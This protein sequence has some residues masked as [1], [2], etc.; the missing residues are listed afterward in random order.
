MKKTLILIIS[1]A[2][3]FSA[4]GTPQAYEAI[5]FITPEKMQAKLGEDEVKMPPAL[6]AAVDR[7]VA[8]RRGQINQAIT[9]PPNVN[10][11]NQSRYKNNTN[12]FVPEAESYIKLPGHANAL[13][14]R[15]SALGQ[16][17][18]NQ[19]AGGLSGALQR[20]GGFQNIMK[21]NKSRQ[22]AISRF[23]AAYLVNQLDK[24]YDNDEFTIKTPTTYAYHLSGKPEVLDDR[25]YLVVQ[26]ALPK[27]LI[28]LQDLKPHE[29]RFVFKHLPLEHLY[30][31]MQRIALFQFKGDDIYVNRDNIQEMWLPDIEKAN[32]EGYNP[33]KKNQR[34]GSFRNVAMYGMDKEKWNFNIYDHAYPAIRAWL[35]KN[36]PL[37]EH[38]WLLLK[39]PALAD[40]E[41]AAQ[42]KAREELTELDGRID[43]ILENIE[44]GGAAVPQINKLL[45]IARNAV[46][47]YDK[48]KMKEALAIANWARHFAQK[49]ITDKKITDEAITTQLQTITQLIQQAGK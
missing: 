42:K 39:N 19:R 12:L 26:K 17:A 33:G 13:M 8:Q 6:K 16:D 46:G 31:V 15:L 40:Q 38:E 34:G 14:E 30:D 24:Q 47:I 10:A 23:I 28:K 9:L 49:N 2:S 37:R 44:E 5:D 11:Y 27:N 22:Q 36:A 20:T 1:F 45:D 32:N 41:T 35:A 48:Q 7:F 4:F 18:N 25:N 21:A 3:I 29:K 43:V